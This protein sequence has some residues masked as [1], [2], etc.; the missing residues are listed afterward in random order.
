[1]SILSAAGDSWSEVHRVAFRIERQLNPNSA[2]AE[3][4]Q[5][6]EDESLLVA[7]FNFMHGM[8]HFMLKINSA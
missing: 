6:D 1:M 5:T 3:D 4:I 2:A 8:C 7:E